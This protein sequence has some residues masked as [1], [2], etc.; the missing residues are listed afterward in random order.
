MAF[1]AS[2]DGKLDEAELAPLVKQLGDQIEFNNALLEEMTNLEER[3]TAMQEEMKEKNEAQ[4]EAEKR[5]KD[6]EFRRRAIEHEK[7]KLGNGG[8]L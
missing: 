3:Q 1:D 7:R 4:Q 2:G 8:D 6:D 5:E